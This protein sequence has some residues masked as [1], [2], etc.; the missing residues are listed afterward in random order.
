M[1]HDNY[2]VNSLGHLTVGGVDT[3]ELAKEYKT[4]LYVV[5]EDKIRERCRVYLSA[6]K[7]HFG[8][9]SLPFY[10]SK[11]L[12]CLGVYGIIKSEGLGVDIVSPGE[13]YTALSAGLD[14][15]YMCFHGNNKTD[16]D[17]EYG[18]ES[19]VGYFVS[20][21]VEELTC[22][23]RAALLFGK[24]QDVLLRITPGID[25]HTFKAVVTG[26][27]DS[28]FGFPIKTG[29]AK[30]AVELALSLPGIRLCGLH[31]HIGSQ[32]FDPEPFV[33]AVRIMTAFM[34][35]MKRDYGYTAEI[36]NL[37]GGFGVRYTE[38]SPDIDVA[39]HIAIVA[40]ELKACCKAHGLTLP[41][42]FMEPGRGIVASAGITLYTAGT[43]KTIEG[44]RSYLSVDG[45]MPDNPRYALY[46]SEY[47]FYVAN[48][49]NAP[50]D[51]ECTVCGRCCESGDL[52]GE[53][54]I[55][56][57]AERG[58]IIAVT[59]TGAYN[60]SMASNYN[61][62]PRPA[63]VFVSGG[64]HRLA[65]RRES[66]EDLCKNERLISCSYQEC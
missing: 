57:R 26:N 7:K 38:N 5:D 51:T 10:A 8:S 1:I 3:V 22:L 28:K 13:L 39:S 32:I 30:K 24:V 40:N 49:M 61:R 20:D 15:R 55:M 52:L 59:V 27:V 54:V 46:N 66:F 50:L 4:P 62:I 56:Q 34:A 12:S 23:S 9:D 31:C 42:V 25:P 14:P 36:L 35:D 60:Y 17:I 63:M 11:A 53:G 45:G 2:G 33:D 58:D 6:M 29:A 18:L 65:V 64:M 41:R 48:K 47:T 44:F 16:E 37:G 43:F 19:G 21:S